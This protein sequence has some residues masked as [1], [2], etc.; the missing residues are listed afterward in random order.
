[1]HHDVQTCPYACPYRFSYVSP[2]DKAG[3]ATLDSR[4][5]VPYEVHG[6]ISAGG[7]RIGRVKSGTYSV[8]TVIFFRGGRHGFGRRYSTWTRSPARC[9]GC[10]RVPCAYLPL[11][12][13]RRR[14]DFTH[15]PGRRPVH[16]C[17]PMS[18]WRRPTHISFCGCCAG[19]HRQHCRHPTAQRTGAVS[20]ASIG[21]L[22]APCRRVA[23]R[24]CWSLVGSLGV[25]RCTAGRVW[26]AASR[27]PDIISRMVDVDGW[28]RG[29][30]ACLACSFLDRTCD[31][32]YVH[33]QTAPSTAWSG[34]ASA[35]GRT[36]G[37]HPA[38]LP[39]I[40]SSSCTSL[41]Q[42]TEGEVSHNVRTG[43]ATFACHYCMN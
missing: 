15:P 19:R 33:Q 27:D 2:T 40:R 10:R 12:S 26:T 41:Q 25:V 42:G 11:L 21:L 36:D 8:R 32:R 20:A 4:L 14:C 29:I 31:L 7:A 16:H 22:R 1:M 37:L 3:V 35:C 23:S 5:H 38:C 13:K 9:S 28:G 17:R 24:S 30:T 18:V 34:Q 6:I 39:L 43:A